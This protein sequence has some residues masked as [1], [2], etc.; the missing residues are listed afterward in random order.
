MEPDLVFDF[1]APLW[2]YSGKGAWHFITLPTDIA[3]AVRL[4]SGPRRG[5][6]QLPVSARIGGTVFKSSIFPDAKSGSYL[7]PV[8]ADVRKRE[9]IAAGDPVRVSLTVNP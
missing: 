9:K 5:F 1:E 3:S 8:K 6:G 7:L 4:F 2:L